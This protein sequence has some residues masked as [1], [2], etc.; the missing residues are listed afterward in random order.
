MPMAA[1]RSCMVSTLRSTWK[2]NLFGIA[3]ILPL[4][5]EN[6]YGGANASKI[7]DMHKQVH[8]D[9]RWIAA[10]WDEKASPEIFSID[11]QATPE[12]QW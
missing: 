11:E 1:I 12:S 5:F 2:P 9:N 7:P 8:D 3:K 4:T 10:L 6:T